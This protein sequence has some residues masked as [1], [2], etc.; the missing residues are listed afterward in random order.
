MKLIPKSS[1]Y[2]L[3]VGGVS[4]RGCGPGGPGFVSVASV[5]GVLAV[6]MASCWWLGTVAIGLKELTVYMD[7]KRKT[8]ASVEIS[9]PPVMSFKES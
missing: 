3:T 9:S 8:R 6:F 5:R 2:S 1:H 7:Q 4:R